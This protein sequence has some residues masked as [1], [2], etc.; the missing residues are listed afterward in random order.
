MPATKTDTVGVQV[1]NGWN[2]ITHAVGGPTVG[3]NNTLTETKY[4]WS[5]DVYTGAADT[6]G[7]VQNGYRNLFDT[8]L[9][10]TPMA[11]FN[12]YVNFDWGQQRLNKTSLGNGVNGRA[13]WY[14]GA[15]AAHS[16]FTPKM[17]VTGRY[18]AFSDDKGYSTGT[19]QTLQEI[20]ATYEYK[21]K[22]GFLG[23]TEYR[24]DWSGVESFHKANGVMSDKQDTVSMAIILVI[25][26]KR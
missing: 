6:P 9:L 8:T 10:L 7:N 25:A 11:K 2:N 4:T 24:H 15:L 20:T 18:E 21:W 23:R 26:P 17:A 5:T 19:S 14:G 13:N 3:F 12:A 1:V 16:Q 22:Y